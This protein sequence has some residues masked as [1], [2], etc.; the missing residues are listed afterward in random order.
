[1]HRSLPN[2][3]HTTLSDSE[4]NLKKTFHIRIYSQKIFSLIH[5]LCNEIKTSALLLDTLSRTLKV[6]VRYSFDYQT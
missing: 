4:Y 2:Y 6:P 5:Q 3:Y 1:M